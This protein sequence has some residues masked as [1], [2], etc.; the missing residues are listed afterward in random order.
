M[1]FLNKSV[2]IQEHTVCHIITTPPTQT[3]ARTPGDEYNSLYDKLKRG[4]VIP[5]ICKVSDEEAR[6]QRNAINRLHYQGNYEY[7]VL[8]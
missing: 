2:S 3:M 4:R 5:N 7:C 1:P 6:H 8:R